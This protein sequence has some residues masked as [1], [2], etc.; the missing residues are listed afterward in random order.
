MK[1][2]ANKY[3]PKMKATGERIKTRNRHNDFVYDGFVGFFEGSMG[4]RRKA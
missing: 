2:R 3:E 4:N 1:K